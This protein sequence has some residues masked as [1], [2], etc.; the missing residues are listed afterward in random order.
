MVIKEAAPS[1]SSSLLDFLS[2]YG[3]IRSRIFIAHVRRASAGSVVYRDTHLFLRELNGREYV[4]AHN[5]T[6]RSLERLELG[7]FRP[8]GETD[9]EYAFCHLLAE[10]ERRRR[11]QVATGGLR[12]A[13]R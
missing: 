4:F 10:I 12:V 8:V 6:L 11:R 13:S 1:V 5:G 9:P 7:R 2:R 3:R